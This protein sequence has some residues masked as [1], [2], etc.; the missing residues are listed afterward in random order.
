MVQDASVLP[1]LGFLLEH[2][3]AAYDAS[4]G[5]LSPHVY[6]WSGKDYRQVTYIDARKHLRIGS[7]PE[8]DPLV[9]G[10]TDAA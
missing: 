6:W 4:P 2:A 8:F 3:G 7:D 9:L 1:T 5:Q 10:L